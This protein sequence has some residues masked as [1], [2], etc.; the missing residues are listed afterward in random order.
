V[1]RSIDPAAREAAAVEKVILESAKALSRFPATQ[2][3]ESVLGHYAR[4]FTGIENGENSTFDTQRELLEELEDQIA[5][6][7]SM[8]VSLEARNIEVHLGGGFAWATYDY[9]FRFRLTGEPYEEDEGR[10]SSI[11]QKVDSRW[12]FKHEHCSSA[13]PEELLEEADPGAPAPQRT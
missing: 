11:L 3:V 10:C 4:D 2:D 1:R 7:T 9:H 6:G 13:C 12:L 8:K 5:R